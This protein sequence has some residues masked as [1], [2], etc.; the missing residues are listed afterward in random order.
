MKKIYLTI[1]LGILLVGTIVAVGISIKEKEVSS[2]D[3]DK[4]KSVDSIEVTTTPIN[5]NQETCDIVY[6][7]T[8]YGYTS[9]KPKPYRNVCIEYRQVEVCSKEGVCEMQNAECL[10]WEKIYYSNEELEAQRDMVVE[11]QKNNILK[12]L[13]INKAKKEEKELK[14]PES[15]IKYTKGGEI[16][17]E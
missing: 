9:Y 3:Y 4:L 2:E 6:I 16:P 15:I 11:N 10:E 8:G 13:E 7:D 17:K 12:R 5:C 1:I 14:V